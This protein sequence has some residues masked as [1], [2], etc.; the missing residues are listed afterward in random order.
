[1]SKDIQEMNHKTQGIETKIVIK[2]GGLMVG[3]IAILEFLRWMPK[4]TWLD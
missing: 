3:G 4:G 2:L 1:M